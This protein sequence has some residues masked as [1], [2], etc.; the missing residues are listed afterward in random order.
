MLLVRR[1]QYHRASPQQ[2]RVMIARWAHRLAQCGQSCGN[3]HA[4]E[5]DGLEVTAKA[6]LGTHPPDITLTIN[7]LIY[8][9]GEKVFEDEVVNAM[10]S[11]A[12]EFT[13]RASVHQN[14][15]FKAGPWVDK[16]MQQIETMPKA[17]PETC[18]ALKP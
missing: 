15:F 9:D 14:G 13:D 2:Q 6:A 4:Y 11:T 17:K 1:W 10:D 16:L 3:A 12:I 5:K 7:A 18:A 8:A